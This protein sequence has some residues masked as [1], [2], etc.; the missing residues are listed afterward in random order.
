MNLELGSAMS[1]ADRE[2]DENSL[3]TG[4]MLSNIINISAVSKVEHF[5]CS[6]AR[7]GML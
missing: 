3:F 4:E 1:V 2:A 5:Y 6:Y 7:D